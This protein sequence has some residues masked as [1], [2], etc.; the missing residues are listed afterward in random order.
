MKFLGK[1]L[2]SV[3][4]ALRSF[5]KRAFNQTSSSSDSTPNQI[6]SP[7]PKQQNQTKLSF[8][9]LQ[10]API[11]N[12][13]PTQLKESSPK[14]VLQPKLT[15]SQ[16]T[17]LE[18]IGSKICP[19]ETDEIRLWCQN[20]NGFD[21]SQ[22]FTIFMEQLQYLQKYEISYLS[23]TEAKLNPYSSYVNEN[24]EAAFQ[25]VYPGGSCILSNQYINRDDLTQYG[26]VFSGV[27][28]KMSHRV[29]NMGKDKLG[30]YNWIDF[31]G[32]SSFLR[33][34]TIYRINPGNDQ[35]SGDD[36]CWIHQ[37][38]ALLLSNCDTDPRK[39]V[40]TDLCKQITEDIR[41]KRNILVC[42]DINED[43]TSS[44]GFNL[45]MMELG[46][47]NLIIDQVGT[48][49][50]YRTHNRGQHIIDGIWASPPL[51]ASIVR[52]G[53]APFS[54]IFPSDHRGIFLDL[55]LKSFLD[56]TTPNVP[57]PAYRR[58]K[59]TIPKRVKAYTDKGLSLW[60]LQRMD[61][62][63]QQLKSILPEANE[64]EKKILLNKVDSQIND[65]LTASEKKCC[66]VGRH[67]TDLFS[68]ELQ[69][70]LRNKRQ[71]Q[72]QLSKILLQAGN[73]FI[74][75]Q[76][77]KNAAQNV[78][79]AKRKVKQCQKNAEP[80]RDQLYD[81]IAKDTL[82]M[83][84]ERRRK[85]QSII[86]Q[87][88]HCENSRIDSSKIRFATKG[89]LPG[90]ISY[91]FIPDISEYDTLE[92]Q[93]DGFDHLNVD[94]I[95]TRTQRH[96]GKDINNWKRIDDI[97]L[98]TKLVS[99]ILI[100]HFG[101][102]SG[103]P[104]ANSLWKSK[105]SDPEFQQSL[106]DGTYIY[107]ESLPSEANTLLQSFKLKPNVKEIPLLPTWNEFR[108][109]VQNAKEKTSSSPSGRHYGHYKSLLQSAPSILR[110]IYDLMCL[111]L[112]YG[113]VL[114]RWKT[115]I[116]TLIC[117]DDNKPYIHR[118]RP[119]HIV[120]AELQFFSK[121][122]WSHKLIGQA[123]HL[124]NI[125]PSQYGGRKNKQAQSSVL[126]TILTFD[127]HRQ[128]RKTF[129][130][131]D[132]D[133]R[134][135][136]DREL[137]HFSVAETRSHGL[138]VN[139][140]K[141]LIDITTQQQFH[142]KT[143]S[144]VS[145]TYY[146]YTDTDPVWGLGQG[147]SWAGSCWQFTATSIEK[148][149]SAD[150]C[151]ATLTNP[152]NDITIRPFMKFFID[153]TTKI[154][155][156]TKNNRSI[157]DQ[158]QINMQKHSNF[159]I[160]TG[161]DM[162][163]DKCRF[164]FIKYAF[165]QNYDPYVLNNE[166]NPGDLI[167]TNMLTNIET[168]I[169][170][171]E[172]N[173][174]RKT[175]GCLLTP[176]NNQEAQLEDL[177]QKILEWKHSMTF[178]SLPP[179]L[180]LRAYETILKPKL[181]YRLATTSLSFQQCDDLIKLIRPLILH[182]HR[183][184][185]HFPKVI[186]A[187]SSLY[188]GYN[189][190]HLYDLQGF[191]KIKFFTH[192]LRQ[193]DDTGN[194]LLLSL[195]FSQLSIGTEE[196][197]INLN[198]SSYSFLTDATWSTHLWEYLSNRELTIDINHNIVIPPQRYNDAYIMDIVYSHFT[199][200]ELI[201]INKIRISLRLLFLSDVIDIR[202]KNILPEIR[203]GITHRSS[204][205]TFPDQTFAPSWIPLWSKACDKI[206]QF[207]SR[208]HLGKWIRYHFKWMAKISIC[209]MFLSIHG[210]T[211][212][213]TP[214]TSQFKPSLNDSES[215]EFLIPVDICQTKCGYRIIAML[216]QTS[217]PPAPSP[218]PYDM[219][220]LFGDFERSNEQEIVNIIKTNKCKMCCDG[221]IVN[222]HGSFAY[223]LAPSG[224]DLPLFEQ[225]APV[226]GDLDQI[227][228]TRCELMGVLACIEYLRYIST[229]F[230]FDRRYFILITADNENAI[231]SPKKSYLSTKYTFSPDIDI[232]LHIQYLLKNTPFNIR[233]QHVR[234]H[235][236]KHKPYSSLSTL[237][238][239]NVKMDTL[240][241]KYFT[242]PTNAPQYSLDSAF[243]Y[244]SSVSFSDP[245]SR[246]SSKYR[247]NLIRHTTG[248]LA[249]QHMSKTLQIR[250]SQLNLIDWD[251][252]SKS[253]CSM[254]NSMRSFI[255]KSIYK[256]LPTIQRQ[257][258]WKQTTSPTCPLC[259]K[260]PDDEDHIL[261]CTNTV[262]TTYRRTKLQALR[263][264]LSALGTDPLLQRHILRIILQ[265]TNGFQVSLCDTS[266][267]C[268]THS[269]INDQITIGV[270]NLLR[271][272]LV[273]RMATAQNT[274][275]RS[276]RNFK[277][278][279]NT[280]A[281]SV[282]KLLFTFSHDI[283]CH[284]CTHLADNANVSYE[285][286]LR[287]S[288]NTMLINLKKNPTSLPLT[289]RHLLDRKQNFTTTATSRSLTSWLNRINLGLERARSGQSRS[290]SDIRN[291]FTPDSQPHHSEASVEEIVFL[292]PFDNCNE[293]H[294][295]SSTD[296]IQAH[297]VTSSVTSVRT[298]HNLPYV[299][300]QNQLSSPIHFVNSF[301]PSTDS[302]IRDL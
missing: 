123:E 211:F 265:W 170:R 158:T 96:N 269:A 83:Y 279:G 30:R 270:G 39:Q 236:D 227:S 43:V 85:K 168:P 31:Y 50:N 216:N 244:G 264:D 275:F 38:N 65:I 160:S 283:W 5:Q 114:D 253:Y 201:R 56:M 33:I 163:F 119:L 191:E 1:K 52:C 150:C 161:G 54:F 206:Q 69:K 164:Y 296:Y 86:K 88:R 76:D 242:S 2:H 261:R 230:V 147:I 109:F 210:E 13:Y 4:T 228:S 204:N 25:R 237:A 35:S 98:V 44:N 80:L 16:P 217:L 218:P 167:I 113:I 254:S 222:K 239:L 178:S 95:W 182:S 149:L 107:D 61:L 138:S 248:S 29:A 51:N 34:Y 82:Q 186:L 53:V 58:L 266:T 6:Q 252:F 141:L 140:G 122:Q 184:H 156:T 223:C 42:G 102:S 127:I 263:D 238:K 196:L 64:N 172:P 188:A 118:L 133:L 101:Q 194:T 3:E 26:G 97:N 19:L 287:N 62:R 60:K 247:H 301:L 208:N 48:S 8:P 28:Q 40:V 212:V 272:I 12:P 190:I 68:K 15:N 124:K 198:Y 189:F 232:I 209:Q 250:E 192:H 193:L 18:W 289:F 258:K 37:R 17:D 256:H 154:C 207:V 199:K 213:R 46:L 224:S 221:S 23:I 268:E 36:T 77:I 197:F 84:P 282:T 137:A 72:T 81:E 152:M 174:A 89:P 162:A 234:G 229:K 240:A 45:A 293:D 90:G 219:F 22:N 292:P 180:I 78:R 126:N 249:E 136:Y 10:R 298:I 300:F 169:K 57:P 139:A 153:D 66:A 175:L 200:E 294:F 99:G 273:W 67:C 205:I 262:M 280:W 103:T 157:L 145:P 295:K 302:D 129:T 173:E 155:N 135:N 27:T 241:K 202:G 271:G 176:T 148:C 24:V 146:T 49:V 92:R 284:R 47:Q 142:I 226:H 32:S 195:Q 93:S 144:G 291:W 63:I 267:P 171:V 285:D 183:T 220:N 70:A 91:V 299:P 128:T 225:H 281:R 87:L 177:K 71:C 115:T 246:I 286:R 134:A 260:E 288:C 255:T 21:I 79:Q 235:Q 233:F 159:V 111:A 120:E 132:D 274:Y 117:K 100:K 259:K 106:L 73:G 214:N 75:Q 41:L 11:S 151:G 74:T 278:Q 94:T 59:F 131:N 165:D 7:V 185:Q 297:N 181:L 14:Y 121:N 187:A 112:S 243:L 179:H 104:F 143:K 130:F 105:L 276:Q 125:S 108:T 231:K 290:H 110:G 55:N 257:Y 20:V 116:T 215:I 245:Y 9:V 166:E 277:S 203:K 251:C